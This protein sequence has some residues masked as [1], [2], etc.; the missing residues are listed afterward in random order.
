[1]IRLKN[2]GS[3]GDC[4]DDCNSGSEDRTYEP[5]EGDT[6]ST[7]S[8][9]TNELGEY[10]HKDKKHSNHVLAGL[11]AL[12]L[13]GSFCDVSL[14]VDDIDYPCHRVVLSSCSRY[15]KAMFSNEM[16]ERS[17]SRIVINGVDS[18][19]LRQL[20][21]Y[22]YTSQVGISRANV[23]SLLSASNL[24]D[25]SSVREACCSYLEHH[26]DETNCLGI[27]SFAEVHSCM[28]LQEKAKV[29][30]C[31]YFADV[32][33]QDEFLNLSSSKLIEFLS[34]DAL[35][36][37]KE[38]HIFE[39][40]LLW[41]N[42][43]P[44]ARNKEFE[45]VLE[46]I[47]LPLMSPYYLLDRVATTAI[48]TQSS[49]CM[50]LVEEA[51][52]Y[53]LL[54]DRRR[55]RFH[56]RVRPRRCKAMVDVIVVVGGEDEKVVLRNV[57]CFNPQTGTWIGLTSLPFAVSKHGV[58]VTGHNV[59]YLAGGEYPDGSASKAAWRF[60][61]STDSW[62]EMA[63]MN[64]A[65]SELGL[66]TV[67]GFIYAIGGWGGDSR[68]GS[69]ERYNPATN[70]WDFVQSLK[71]PLTSPAVASMNGLL[72]I[73]GGAVVDDGDGVDMTQC[74]DPKT[75]H[76]TELTPMLIPR[77]GAVACAINGR[78]YVMGGWHASS[79][80]TNK[81]EC[82]DPKKNVWELRRSMK[83]KR[84]KPG[85]AVLESSVYVCGGEESWDKHH[86][87]VEVYDPEEDRWCILG[88]MPHWRSW[89]GCATIMLPTDFMSEE[90]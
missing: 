72:Y 52:S 55:E 76:W 66:A 38:E 81:V 17:Q 32:I 35:E 21:E 64:M 28:E 90:K 87:S 5:S 18:E 9:G 26:M 24:L 53:H 4:N 13:E 83:E 14:S 20:I 51:K 50:K 86:D 63:P 44:D 41:V 77:S 70:R 80:N 29:F 43:S 7:T 88:V 54:P 71:I 78:V 36:V 40:V 42:H 48:V 37:D 85:I 19:T 57:D 84:Y 58:A 1:M 12:R 33:R 23:Q 27:H 15:F 10:I 75:D 61:P 6:P 46:H 34:S 82:Y 59:L 47:R 3:R 65:R 16:S 89:L 8:I 25:V 11:N 62:S 67:D 68:L 56:K 45:Q 22:A 74:Y 49:Q 79:E 31:Q 69:V 2:E 60:D 39:A 73:T 30:A